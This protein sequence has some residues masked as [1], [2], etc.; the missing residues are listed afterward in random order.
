M[1][2]KYLIVG[3]IHIGNNKGNSIFYKTLMDY[4]NWIIDICNDHS[5]QNIIFLG[6]IFDSRTAVSLESLHYATEFFD[7]LQDK[8]IDIILG[9][10]DIFFNHSTE[11]HSLSPFKNHPNITIHEKVCKRDKLTFCPWATTLEDIPESEYV[12]GHFDIVGYELTKGKISNHGFRGVDLMKKVNKA[13]FSGH[14]HIFQQRIYDS[15]PLIYAGSAFSLSFN[16]AGSNKFV[17]ILDTD[18]LEVEKIENTISPKFKYVRSESDINGIKGDFVSIVGSDPELVEK[19]NQ[20]APLFVRMELVDEF[21]NVSTTEEVKEFKIID[22][23]AAIHD[24]SSNLSD[25]WKLL[26]EG[27]KKVAMEVEKMYFELK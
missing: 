6:D 24:F 15:K 18:T 23:P 11:I 19:V 13:V 25:E 9:N 10:H 3:D 12:F 17:H 5:L 7:L 21:K 26:A 14:Y 16:D 1:S 22:V 8:N 2:N 4:G 27:K 20:Q